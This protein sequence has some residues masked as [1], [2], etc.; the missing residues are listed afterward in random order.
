MCSNIVG[1][2]ICYGNYRRGH[3]ISSGFRS[4]TFKSTQ[5]HGHIHN[6]AHRSASCAFGAKFPFA[7]FS[8][9]K[10]AK[11]KQIFAKMLEELRTSAMLLLFSFSCA[12]HRK[13]D[14]ASFDI[15][16]RTHAKYNIWIMR[17]FYDQI[18]NDIIGLG[19]SETKRIKS[20]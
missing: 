12:N 4:S 3:S 8:I 16:I 20:I 19:R 7:P 13:S 11:K 2:Q 10:I 9:H 1:L 15:Y 17:T 18:S 5:K 14:A 6:R